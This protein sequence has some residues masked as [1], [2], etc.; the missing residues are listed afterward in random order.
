MT[1]LQLANTHN[2]V[3]FL[4]KPAESKGFEQIVDFLNAHTIKYA[5]TVNLTIYTSCIEQFWAIVKVKTVNGEVQLQALVDG[6]KIIVTQASIR[7]DLQLNDE[8]GM[9]CLPNATIFKELTRMSLSAKTIAWNE[10]SSTMASAIICLAI[11]QKFNFSKYIFESMVKNLDNDGKFLMY[12]RFV[13]VFL[14][15]Q[16]E[17]MQS[18]KRIYVTPSHTKK[19]FRNM[20]RV[21]KGFSGRET[22]LFPTMVVQ[23]Q[24][25]IGEGLAIPTYPHHTSTI[26]QPLT[27]QPQKKQRSRRPKRKDTKVPQPSGPITNVADEAIY[28][29][30]DDDLERATTT[31]TSLDAEQ[32]RGNIN[33]T[34]SKATPNEPSSPGT[35]SGGGPRRQETIGAIVH[36]WSENVS[37]HSNDPLLIRVIDLE[38]TKTSQ[39]QEITSL[40]LR[41]KKLEKKGGSRT[42]KLKILYKI[43]RSE[44]IVSSDEASLGDQEDASKQGR[45]I[46]DTDK[47]TEITLVDETQESHLAQALAALKYAK[48]QEKANVVEKPSESITTTPTLTTTTAATTITATSTKPKEKIQ[49]ESKAKMIELEP[50]KFSKKDQLK[51]DEEVAQRLQAEFD[52][53]QRIEREKAEVNIVLKETWDDIQAK[54]EANQLLAKRL[55]ARE[56]EELTIKERAILFQQ[57]LEKRRKHFVAKRAEEKRNRPPTKAQ[58]RSIISKRAG[59]ELEQES[60][61]KQKVDEDKETAELKSLMEVISDEE[62]VDGSLKMYLVF[63]HMLKSFDI[64]DLETLHKLVKAMYG[65]TRLVEDLDLVLYGDLKTIFD[66]HIEDQVWKNQSD[67]RVLE[68]KLYDSCGVHLLRKQNVHIHMLVEN[69]YPLTPPII[70]NMLNKKLKADHWNKMCYQLLQLITKSSRINK[71]FRS[72][73]LVINEAF[74]EET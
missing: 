54:L 37:K 44:R 1:T 38:K 63:S 41:V 26:I 42:H 60:I 27:S 48:V 2:L 23:N 12:P 56:Q 5:L 19:I 39:A 52:E 61:K 25:D 22:P 30:R 71:V 65:S 40:K 8:E 17:G 57:L 50:E 69:R 16:L 58:Q 43:G 64:E 70:T 45:K 72:I 11:N 66:P 59:D 73:L 21:G 13:Q 74:N 51:L 53:Q 29:E 14:D 18:H 3:A 20:K 34:H 35:S 47:D 7:S 28:E 49:D 33:K 6:M 4:A 68:W 36:S 15:K 10:F 31:A 67:Y 9:D 24:V 46:D 62:K 55:Q 32:D